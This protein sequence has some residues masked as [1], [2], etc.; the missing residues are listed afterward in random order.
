MDQVNH[1]GCVILENSRVGNLLSSYQYQCFNNLYFLEPVPDN[2]ANNVKVAIAKNF[3]EL[4]TNNKKYVLIKFYALWCGHCK[5][6]IPVYEELGK[7][8][9]G[10]DVEIVKMDKQPTMCRHSSTCAVS[11][12]SS[13]CQNSHKCR[14]ATGSAESWMTL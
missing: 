8:M 12:P 14:K 9:A 7:K 2:S 4:V 6:L 11:P 10:E 5:K 3:D 13:G 1:R